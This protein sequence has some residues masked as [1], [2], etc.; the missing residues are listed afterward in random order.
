MGQHSVPSCLLCVS[1][2]GSF[3]FSN[4]VSLPFREIVIAFHC[5]LQPI[6]L[7]LEISAYTALSRHGISSLIIH[8]CYIII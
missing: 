8:I 3:W 2:S 7:D 4:V 6:R 1:A 5:L